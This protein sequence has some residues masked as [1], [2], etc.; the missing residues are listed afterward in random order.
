VVTATTDDS[1]AG[2]AGSAQEVDERSTFVLDRKPRIALYVFIAVEVVAFALYLWAGRKRWFFHDEWNVLINVDGGDA[3]SLLRPTNEHWTTLPKALYRVLFNLF[4]LNSYTPYQLVSISCH[5]IA[6]AL[7]RVVMRRAGVSAWMATLVA[8]VFLLFGAGD[9]NILR[10]FQVTFIGALVFGLV[11]ILLADHDGKINRWD[12]LGLLAGVAALMCSGVGI[13]MV[14]AVTASAL[15]RRGWRAAL[16]HLLPL[17]AIYLLWFFT[18]ADDGYESPSSPLRKVASF[19]LATTTATFDAIGH[20]AVV[21]VLLGLVL[22]VGLALAW[23][24][25]FGVDVRRRAAPTAGLLFGALCFVG[26]TAWSRAELGAAFASQSRYVHIVAA[27]CLPAVAVG[28]DAIARRWPVLVPAV[29]V[30][31]LVGIPG[32]VDTTF[33]QT[34]RGRG[35]RSDRDVYLAFAHVPA[36]ALAP[37]WVRPDPNSA[38]QLTLGWLRAAMAEGRLPNPRNID[39]EVEREATFRHELQLVNPVR[40][41]PDC[42][43]L[44]EPVQVRLERGQWVGFTGDILV[45]E[46]GPREDRVV[47]RFSG[48]KRGAIQA[49]QRPLDL[50]IR[51]DAR[52]GEPTLCAI[53]PA[54]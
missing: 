29:V 49:T 43:P 35:Q 36:A 27:L 19:A 13:A 15:I 2:A 22:V 48:G 39:P 32:N 26:L 4:G 1:G 30:L 37:D 54:G 11:H 5:L 51:P 18:Y 7:L 23:S 14:A 46:T 3:G 31:L 34:G 9:H 16:F 20:Y 42:E 6:A 38:A 25:P 53:P 8:C 17:A 41:L 50:T 52:S 45:F 33:H 12:W 40:P 21:G 28:A 24:K 44:T 10:A 47:L